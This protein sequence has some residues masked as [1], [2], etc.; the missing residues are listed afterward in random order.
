MQNLSTNIAILL[1]LPMFCHGQIPNFIVDGSRWVYTTIENS[2]PGQYLV[3]NSTEQNIIHGDTLIHG[4]RYQ[5]LYTTLHNELHV[6]SPPANPVIHSYDSTGPA[7][8]RYDTLLR[9]VFYMPDIDS[10]ERL[11]YDFALTAGDTLPMQSPI[12]PNA[13]IK[14]IDTITFFGSQVKRFFIDIGEDSFE[15]FNFIIEGLGGSNGLLYF[16]PVFASLSGET[17]TTFWNCFQSADSTFMFSGWD[18]PFVDFVSDIKPVDQPTTLIIVPNPTN[19]CYTLTI[20]EELLNATLL[21]MDSAGRIMDNR[22][23]ETLTYTGTLNAPGIYFW[24]VFRDHQSIR[25]GTL[26]CK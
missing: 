24:Q 23:L 1:L 22:P 7:F 11:I 25:S 9:K 15:E 3:H 17:F 20:G 2:E 6:F 21:V 12:F 19:G 5:K 10:K 18:C 16:Q 4:T 14:S 13:V 8:L 26:I